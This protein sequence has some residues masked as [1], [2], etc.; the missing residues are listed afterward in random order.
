[1]S[2]VLSIMHR[3]SVQFQYRSE[4][5]PWISDQHLTECGLLE[6]RLPGD[7]VLADR[8]F[9]VQESAGLCCAQG[10]IPPFTKGQSQLSKLEVDV[11]HKICHVRIHVERGIK[12]ASS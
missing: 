6:K 1:M 8:G 2:M 9:N 3:H 11:S 4:I 10:V 12:L 7:I 5:Q